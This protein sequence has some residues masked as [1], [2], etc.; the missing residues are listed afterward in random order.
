M[1]HVVSGCNELAKKQYQIRHDARVHLRASGNSVENMA[2]NAQT[3]GT[4]TFQALLA[5]PKMAYMRYSGT[6]R[7]LLVEAFNIT[8]VV[9][10]DKAAK[11]LTIIDFCVPWDGNVK[12]REDEKMV[13]YSTLCTE[14][15][16]TFRV[17]TEAIPIVIGALGTVP[18]SLPEFLKTLGVP[19]VI[20]CMQTCALLGSQRILKNVLSI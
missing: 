11:K 7:F 13:K 18:K 16:T 5:D 9:L 14:I 2:F 20:R 19:D 3:S 6:V 12:A 4:I 17:R 8:D 10:V 15:Q 1:K